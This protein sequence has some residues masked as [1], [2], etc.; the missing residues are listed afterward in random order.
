M[1]STGKPFAW[2]SHALGGR[3]W[4]EQYR[5]MIGQPRRRRATWRATLAEHRRSLPH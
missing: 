2:L 3:S 4:T 1:T 5:V